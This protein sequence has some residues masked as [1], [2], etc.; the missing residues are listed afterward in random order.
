MSEEPKKAAA[1]KEPEPQALESNE[2]VEPKR[3]D[4][5]AT[6]KRILKGAKS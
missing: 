1:E 2:T 5:I 6:F 4:L 3:D